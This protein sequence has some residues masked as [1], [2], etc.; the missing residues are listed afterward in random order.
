MSKTITKQKVE[1]AVNKH[2]I[3]YAES[4]VDHA[5]NKALCDLRD[6]LLRGK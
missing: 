6:E 4:D 3:L 1:D 2:F 5:H